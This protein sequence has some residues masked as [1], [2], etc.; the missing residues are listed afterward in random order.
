MSYAEQVVCTV[1]KEA[2]AQGACRRLGR[3]VQEMGSAGLAERG[4]RAVST[5]R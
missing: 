2:E 3:A 5:R 4:S 1:I